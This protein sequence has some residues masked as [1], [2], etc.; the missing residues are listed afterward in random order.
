MFDRRVFL[1]RCGLGVGASWVSALSGRAL[2][3]PSEPSQLPLLAQ[4][5]G[6]NGRE[7][8]VASA[9]SEFQT[10]LKS[11][12]SARGSFIQQVVNTAGRVIETTEGS[13]V[14]RRPGRFRWEVRKPYEQLLV[15]DG[16]QLYFYDRDL[17]QV[18]VR[19]LGDALAATPA[20][21]LFGKEPLDGDFRFIEAGT[22]EGLL[23]LEA[24]PLQRESGIERIVI[25]L[26]A[27]LPEALEV[28]DALG[29]TSRFSFR[30]L[31]RNP[32]ID[33][34]LF[35]FRAPAGADVIRQ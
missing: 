10:F 28:S 15:A 31:E 13:F 22:R 30:A 8:P 33:E 20:A 11:T 24:I 5:S 23:W 26:K 9:Y 7:P 3:R 35:T 12:R 32:A 17:N 25:G 21:I 18:T 1:I 2:A 14:F 6:G 16:E 19:K 27:G 29:R 4:A 34:T